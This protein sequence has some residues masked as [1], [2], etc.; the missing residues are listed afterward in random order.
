[1]E[2]A[3]QGVKKIFKG[4]WDAL[5]DIAKT[6]INLIIGLINGLTGAV[7]DAINWIIDGINELSFTTP[8]WLPGDLGG[9]TFGFD[10]SQIDIPEIPKL[11]QGAVIPPNSEFLA[12][13]GDR[14][15]ARI[16]RHRWILSHRLFCRLLCLT[17]EQAEIRR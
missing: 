15:V 4:V 12:V 5:V 3:W 14:S 17:A 10:L 13:L 16:S 1:M 6:P 11:A 9:Q 2:K 7:E 8:D